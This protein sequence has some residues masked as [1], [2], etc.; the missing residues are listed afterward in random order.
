MFADS[1]LAARLESIAAEEMRL[2]ARTAKGF[3]VSG[4]V[5]MLDIMGGV[6]IFVHNGSPVNRAMGLG[7]GEPVHA[8]EVDRLEEFFRDRG[9]RALAVVCPLAD[10]SLVEQLAIAEW[11]PDGFENVLVRELGAIERPQLPEC[12]EIFEATTGETRALWARIAAAGFSAPLPPLP[13]QVTLAHVISAR[14][15]ARLFI[16]EVDGAPAGVGEL[17]I[18]GEV[19][20][21]SA[22]TTLPRYR[23][24]GVQRALQ[25]VRMTVAAQAGCGLA[26]S[27]AL[28]GSG[29]QRNM[30]RLGFCVAY[31][32]VDLLAPKRDG[33]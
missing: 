16:A 6:A 1:T 3:D 25:E 18:D 33:V 28:P 5:S 8:D 23:R 21:L 7:F 24:R 9:E 15:G 4:A 17:Y 32:R 20:W 27:E 22:D 19:G 12:V 10:P 30:E 11:V 2:I 13:E 29:S 31:T 14:P 26:V